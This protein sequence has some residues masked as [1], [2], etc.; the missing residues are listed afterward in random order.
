MLFDFTAEMKEINKK[1]EPYI[2]RNGTDISII[3][4]AP[5]W[6]ADEYKK[7]QALISEYLE[8]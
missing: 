8:D 6:V 7:M 4:S 3:A 2:V 1:I 5:E